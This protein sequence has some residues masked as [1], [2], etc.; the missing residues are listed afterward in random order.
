M[1]RMGYHEPGRNMLDAQLGYGVPIGTEFGG[2]PRLRLATA[3]HGGDY[4]VGYAMRTREAQRVGLKLA[5]DAQ[6]R[7]NPWT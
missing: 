5:M 6:A 1:H 2:T 3:A 7:K 4:R